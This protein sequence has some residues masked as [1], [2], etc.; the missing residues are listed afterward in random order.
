[1]NINRLKIIKESKYF[2][3]VLKSIILLWFFFAV[4]DLFFKPSTDS[5]DIRN[6]NLVN[7][8]NE[9]KVD[10]NLTKNKSH[11]NTSNS[12]I[13]NKNNNNILFSYTVSTGEN[14][15]SISLKFN[16]SKDKLKQINAL[17]N[18]QLKAGTII[19]VPVKLI[20]NVKKGETLYSIAV[21]YGTT[22]KILK[23]VNKLSSETDIKVGQNICIP[24]L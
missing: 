6:T 5:S 7:N 10:S 11:N 9:T 22:R 1:M 4:Y 17:K 2:K 19:K 12:I 23:E 16:T 3:P 8:I 13:S 18:E 21:K 24:L 20:H 14:I 15:G